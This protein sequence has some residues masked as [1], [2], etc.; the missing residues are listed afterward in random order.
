MFLRNKH[1]TKILIFFSVVSFLYSNIHLAF[2]KL[3]HLN[4]TVC[5]SS[6]FHYH[7]NDH[8]DVCKYLSF[9]P[10]QK[11]IEFNYQYFIAFQT[12]EYFEIN[13]QLVCSFLFNVSNKSPPICSKI[14]IH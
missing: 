11:F 12:R 4:D 6:S 1:T 3:E 7:T 5:I 10:F 2:H 9:F 14:V 13:T 8:N